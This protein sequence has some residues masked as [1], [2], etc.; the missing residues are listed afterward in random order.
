LFSQ[1]L[2]IAEGGFKTKVK[3]SY[4]NQWITAVNGTASIWNWIDIYGD[5]ALYKNKK[6][7][8]KFIYDSGIRLNF[9]QD[10]FELYFPVYSSNG[11]DVSSPNYSQKIRFIFTI[12]TNTVVNLFTRKWF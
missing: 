2:I 1:Q 10:Y 8:A 5:I 11:W 9:V 12:S 7:D 6:I 3:N 4:A